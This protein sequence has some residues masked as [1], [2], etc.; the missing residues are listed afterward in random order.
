[1]VCFPLA[2]PPLFY[3][4]A[5][6]E[7]GVSLKVGIAGP[8]GSRTS[9]QSVY[10]C[11]S[12]TPSTNHVL[13]LSQVAAAR[14]TAHSSFMVC[15]CL[16]P[17]IAPNL[18]KTASVSLTQS[19]YHWRKPPCQERCKLLRAPP[20]PSSVHQDINTLLLCCAHFLHS[21]HSHSI[22]HL[23]FLC[24]AGYHPPFFFF[25]E[26]DIKNIRCERCEIF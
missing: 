26:C 24:T 22:N 4:M 20:L 6:K 21:I 19:P 5:P 7:K 17:L 16:P 11:P 3:L 25:L 10:Q 18:K 13:S 15:F 14:E 2:T 1:M 8:Y 9:T 12:S 23:A